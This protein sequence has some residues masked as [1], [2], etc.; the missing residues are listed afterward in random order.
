M[1]EGRSFVFLVSNTKQE[2]VWM[3]ESPWQIAKD[4]VHCWET[5]PCSGEPERFTPGTPGQK[6]SRIFF[7]G[8]CKHVTALHSWE[9]GRTCELVW[10]NHWSV[11]LSLRRFSPSFSDKS[12][13]KVV[14][15]CSIKP[16]RSLT[17]HFISLGQNCKLGACS[18]MN[19]LSWST[20][21][22]LV[23][24]CGFGSSSWLFYFHKANPSAGV[25]LTCTWK[26]MSKIT[27]LMRKMLLASCE[28]CF[29]HN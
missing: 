3:C 19:F 7:P 27:A 25:S 28:K 10:S 24:K 23:G 22:L 17:V 20:G 8:N 9:T 6:T 12:S 26:L 11:T 2:P 29:N 16:V 5:S 4:L 14:L 1:K 13:I 21:E 18:W 15:S